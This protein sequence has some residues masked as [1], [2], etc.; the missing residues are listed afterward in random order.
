[1]FEMYVVIVKYIIKIN[2]NKYDFKLYITQL[3]SVIILFLKYI[4]TYY[5]KLNNEM[6]VVL[7]K[8][9]YHNLL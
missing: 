6:Y 4:L 1:M 9:K 8:Y 3:N 5:I 7:I 2:Y